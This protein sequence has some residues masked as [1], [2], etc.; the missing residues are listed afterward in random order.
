VIAVGA[1]PYQITSQILVQLAEHRQTVARAVL[2]VQREVAQRL[3]AKPGTKAYGRLSVLG[4]YS[5]TIETVLTVPR[6]AFFPQPAVDSTCLRL[7]AH[8]QPQPAVA[9]E[10][11]FFALVKA[12][13]SHRR[14]TLVNCLGSEPPFHLPRATAEALLRACGL[15]VTV[16]GE[17]LSLREFARLSDGLTRRPG[18]LTFT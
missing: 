4:Q 7:R 2:V 11:H 16:R 14:K 8:P 12:A 10:R 3:T 6:H 18:A 17:A 5:W 13:F 1:I 15:P 9:D